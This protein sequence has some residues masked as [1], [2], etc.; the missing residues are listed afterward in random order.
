MIFIR[1]NVAAPP[2]EEE[3]EEEEDDCLTKVYS[4]YSCK[5][6]EMAYVTGLQHALKVRLDQKTKTK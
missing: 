3:E 4:C 6:Q 1:N 2:K 5:G